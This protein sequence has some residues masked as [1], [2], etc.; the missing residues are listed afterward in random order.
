MDWPLR[1]HWLPCLLPA[2]GD[3]AAG[4]VALASAFAA[5]F[6]RFSDRSGG[7]IPV[8]DRGR[9]TDGRQPLSRRKWRPIS[10]AG[11]QPISAAGSWRGSAAA[12]AIHMLMAQPS[13]R[14]P[15]ALCG[16]VSQ[17]A[18]PER[19]PA[20]APVPSSVPV[21]LLRWSM[22]VS[23]HPWTGSDPDRQFFLLGLCSS[24]SVITLVCLISYK[25][26]F[27]SYLFQKI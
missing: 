10:D 22:G 11:W 18:A 21:R 19:T 17:V 5:M 14:Q 7:V 25:N 16:T 3:I 23:L 4:V 8:W 2:D 24:P 1:R 9:A 27:E 20:I 6:S 13:A 12:G 26:I 15:A